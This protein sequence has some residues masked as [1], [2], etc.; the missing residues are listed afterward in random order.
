MHA[1][2]HHRTVPALSPRALPSSP[3]VGSS[4]S[5]SAPAPPTWTTAASAQTSCCMPTTT[6]PTPGCR[7]PPTT[8]CRCVSVLAGARAHLHSK[9][10]TH[11][12]THAHTHTQTCEHAQTHA[13]TQYKLPAS[14]TGPVVLQWVYFA[15]QSCV[16]R[17]CDRTFCGT[18]GDGEHMRT[19]CRVACMC[20]SRRHHHLCSILPSV[21]RLAYTLTPA[22]LAVRAAAT[23]LCIRRP[24]PRHRRQSR[25][26]C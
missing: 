11:T 15:M 5:G 13:H 1:P 8:T 12:H 4:T 26:L 9:V 14:I 19:S 25:V 10:H 20:A 18:Y 6:S 7:L 21:T 23:R 3:V 17:G 24:Q 2:L 16:E 22:L